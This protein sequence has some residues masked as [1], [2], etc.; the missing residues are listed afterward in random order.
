MRGRP[1]HKASRNQGPYGDT[2]AFIHLVL[3]EVNSP[4]NSLGYYF[5]PGI[6]LTKFEISLH[7]KPFVVEHFFENL[8]ENPRKSKHVVTRPYFYSTLSSTTSNF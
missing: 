8:L 7:P 5:P 1:E 2:R 6:E 4:T 3:L